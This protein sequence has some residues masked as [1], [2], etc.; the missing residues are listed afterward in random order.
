MEKL[1]NRS[2]DEYL[3][4]G[5]G[6]FPLTSNLC[7]I[8]SKMEEGPEVFY[9]DDLV[10]TYDSYLHPRLEVISL[11]LD[12][13][14]LLQQW[15]PK[16]KV[17]IKKTLLA[18][19]LNTPAQILRSQRVKKTKLDGVFRYVDDYQKA[20][21][22]ENTIYPSQKANSVSIIVNYKD[23]LELMERFLRSLSQ[24]II[25]KDVELLLVNNQSKTEVFSQV[26]GLCDQLL[27][28]KISV[29]HIVYDAPFNHSEQNNVAAQQAN[30]EV[31]LFINNDA[32][33]LDKNVVEQISNWA[34]EPNIASAGVSILGLNERVVSTGIAVSKHIL[35]PDTYVVHET[36]RPFLKDFIHETV[37]NT[38]ACAAVSKTVWEK[39][40]GLD[41]TAFPTQYNDADF[42]LKCLEQ[43]LSHVSVGSSKVFHEP[44][45][46]EERNKP[47]LREDHKRLC[48]L[49]PKMSN[50]SSKELTTRTV[51]WQDFQFH[52]TL[53]V[54]LVSVGLLERFN[55]NWTRVKRKI[56]SLC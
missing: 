56:A 11:N 20:F 40:G 48:K 14:Y 7:S 43:G 27:N 10:L 55:Y 31:L 16:S 46:S 13:P 35:Y 50:F 4:C 47:K 6:Y 42:S 34:M 18:N 23:G 15:I 1:V 25:C 3:V 22:L 37:G 33:F 30:G 45:A 54:F 36:D 9:W 53:N 49:H 12:D 17:A 39:I 26:K 8:L 5:E 2:G 24:Q 21:A 41:G 44:G 29:K 32:C 38:F 19:N 28:Q 51:Q 52:F